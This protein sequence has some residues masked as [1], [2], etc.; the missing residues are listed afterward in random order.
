MFK[1]RNAAS[2]RARLLNERQSKLR[3]AIFEKAAEQSRQ[4]KVDIVQET[5]IIGSNCE[6][7]G[8][9]RNPANYVDVVLQLL[10]YPNELACT[11][12]HQ[13][14]RFAGRMEYNPFGTTMLA[15]AQIDPLYP[16]GFFRLK[17]KGKTFIS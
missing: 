3:D 13:F 5:E 12:V 11:I 9:E 6:I 7:L 4:H 10:S 15:F 2:N 16:G 14:S 17:I 8:K 1:R